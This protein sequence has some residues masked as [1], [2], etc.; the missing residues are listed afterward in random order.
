MSADTIMGEPICEDEEALVAAMNENFLGACPFWKENLEANSEHLKGPESYL[1]SMKESWD[2]LALV[3][4]GGKS[5]YDNIEH[6]RAAQLLGWKIVAVDKLHSTLRD[7]GIVPDLTVSVDPQK[8]VLKM[9]DKVDEKDTVALSIIQDKEMVKSVCERAGKVVFY[10]P[11]QKKS[12]IYRLCEDKY[13][14]LFSIYTGMVAG[15]IAADAARLCLSGEEK[16]VLLIGNEFCWF[17]KYDVPE[18][19]R[20]PESPYCQK[21][22][23]AELDG[24]GK[25]YTIEAFIKSQ[26]VMY[27]LLDD[28]DLLL[29]DCSGGILR[30]CT[31]GKLEEVIHEFT[32]R[33]QDDGR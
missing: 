17:D 3:V 27:A 33:G 23:S 22:Y 32:L 4:G 16:T 12:P 15:C 25:V 18:L 24:V 10:E 26:Y 9:C 1:L 5:A 21:I 14:D 20:S 31:R 8:H 2:N 7:C 19:Y 6:I 29:I 28:L 11:A 30:C 13:P